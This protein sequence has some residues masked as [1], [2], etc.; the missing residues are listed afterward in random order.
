MAQPI[1]ASERRQPPATPNPI[2]VDRIDERR[3]HEAEGDEGSKLPSFSERT[4]GDGRGGVHE[5]HLE[6]ESSGDGGCED[7]DGQEEASRPEKAPQLAAD[8]DAELL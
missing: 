1:V 2:R 3:Y 4:G 8:V 7:R 5:H 6:Q